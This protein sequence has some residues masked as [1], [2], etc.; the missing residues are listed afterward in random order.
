MAA[1][2]P[3]TDHGAYLDYLRRPETAV[4]TITVTEA[5]YL[6]RG[7]GRLDTIDERVAADLTTLRAD[8]SAAVGTLPAKLVAGLAARRAAEAGPITVLSCDN[9]P[10]NGQVAAAVVG[11][12]ATLLDPELA[13]WIEREVDFA[14]SMV[15]RITPA[16][17]DGDRAEVAEQRHYLDAS[18]VP[19]EPY[20][21]WVISGD[22][23]GR[24]AALGDSRRP[25]RG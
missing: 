23:P 17:T 1:V 8:P 13:A 22:F 11:D 10:H 14:T 3:A 7:D 9:L 12:L 16:T 2:H 15:D 19:T 20:S 18:P 24:P 4:I 25:D 21:E 5:G 6:R